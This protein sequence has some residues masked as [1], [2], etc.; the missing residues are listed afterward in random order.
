MWLQVNRTLRSFCTEA[1]MLVNEKDRKALFKL[2]A[3][4]P[5]IDEYMDPKA[6]TARVTSKARAGI[7]EFSN[8]GGA[9]GASG[10]IPAQAAGKSQSGGKAIVV[11]HHTNGSKKKKAR[12]I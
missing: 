8:G 5:L 1:K 3:D 9:G 7:R 11:V 2:V 4:C 12:S 10:S 6:L